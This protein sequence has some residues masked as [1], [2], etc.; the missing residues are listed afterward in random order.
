MYYELGYGHLV[1]ERWS[2]FDAR[3]VLWRGLVQTTRKL[4][5]FAVFLERG[6]SGR[7][8]RI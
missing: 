8:F 5:V 2:V 4:G 3:R 6:R 1:D 7:H